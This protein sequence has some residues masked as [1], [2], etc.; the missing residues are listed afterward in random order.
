MST[1]VDA[2]YLAD[3]VILLRYFEHAGAVRTLTL[4]RPQAL[5]SFNVELH[6]ALLGDAPVL[7]R[8]APDANPLKP[9][10]FNPC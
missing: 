6:Q 1:P 2:S 4:N 8:I 7:A 3:T 10:W 5:N 9:G